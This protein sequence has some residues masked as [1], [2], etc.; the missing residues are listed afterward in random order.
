V[1]VA[2]TRSAPTLEVRK[3]VR[4]TVGERA[5]VVN[6]EPVATAAADADA[7]TGPYLIT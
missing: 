3:L 5:A 2:V 6:F 1:R 4:A 7:V